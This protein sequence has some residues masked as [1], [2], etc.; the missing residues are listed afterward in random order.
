MGRLFGAVSKRR[1]INSSG[2]L[3]ELT[4]LAGLDSGDTADLKEESVDEVSLCSCGCSLAFDKNTAAVS[5]GDYIVSYCG[6]FPESMRGGK[7]F[8]F[9]EERSREENIVA[10]Y[11]KSGPEFL[12]KVPGIFMLAL[13]DRKERRLLIAS[14]RHGYFPIYFSS[15]D[16]KFIFSSSIKS[17]RRS[18]DSF[19]MNKAALIEYLFFD[20][21]YGNLTFYD[22]IEICGYGDFIVVDIRRDRIYRDKYFRYYELFDIEQYKRNHNIDAPSE[23][24]ERM[25]N[26]LDRILER[27]D[28]D[29]FGVLCGG[30][31]DC[32]YVTALIEKK[33]LGIPICCSNMKE[34]R[35][36]EKD[37]AG[38]VS[39][40][41]KVPLIV[42]QL[43]AGTYY[44]LLIK[45]IYDFGQPIAHPNQARFYIGI[46][47][48]I[49][50]NLNN[51]IM[52]IASDLLF[53]GT[54]NVKSLYRYLKLSRF[55]SFMPEKVKDILYRITM[56]SSVLDLELRTRNSLS[57][58]AD[59]GI[60]NLQRASMQKGVRSSLSGIQDPYERSIKILMI[61]NLCDYQ[62]HLLNRRYEMGILSG[63]SLYFPFLDI[64]VLKFAINL[65]VK[66]SLNWRKSKKVVREA[67]GALLGPAIT[68]RPK[69]AGAVPIDDWVIPLSFLLKNGFVCSALHCKYDDLM[70]HLNGDSKAIWNMIDVEIWGRLNFLGQGPEEII[71]LIN[72]NGIESNSFSSVI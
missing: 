72:S 50:I 71:D 46:R 69:W 59:L 65:P 54:G 57:V 64:D 58:L 32:S 45:S 6:F 25:D 20:A 19:S 5:G 26:S 52:G 51:Q 44:P 29:S 55:V 66:Y 39:E 16:R 10:L 22:N 8:D 70:S 2:E 60:G 21:I 23:L 56:N 48:G 68:E 9:K 61:E 18:S 63:V 4:R 62:Q 7:E 53:A 40:Y 31:I 12:K 27:G 14:D 67:A 17:I 13:F 24:N 35:V 11:R 49:N 42:N 43:T 34:S 15:S 1:D 41:L 30:G 37:L 3:R 33:G 28:P 36:S 38:S 47:A